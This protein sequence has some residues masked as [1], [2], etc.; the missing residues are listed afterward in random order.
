MRRA[1][2]PDAFAKLIFDETNGGSDAARSRALRTFMHSTDEGRSWTHV[3]DVPL[4]VSSHITPGIQ[5][6]DLMAGALRHYQILRGG[7]PVGNSEWEQAITHLVRLAGARSQDF[8]VGGETYYGL[9]TMPDRYYA[10][11]PGP[12]SF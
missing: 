9:Y 1:H 2:A 11:P 6:A 3:L 10:N 7:G 5:L 8:T 12:R 4:F